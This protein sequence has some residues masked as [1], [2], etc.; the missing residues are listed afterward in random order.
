MRESVDDGNRLE[1]VFKREYKRNNKK[2]GRK[3]GE[4]CI[5]TRTGWQRD[6]IGKKKREEKEA[7]T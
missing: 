7:I 4:K 6:S 3:R 1:L 2:K 5:H